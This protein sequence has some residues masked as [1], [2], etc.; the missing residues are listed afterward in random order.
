[1][2]LAVDL[3]FGEGQHQAATIRSNLAGEGK[4]EHGVQRDAS[5]VSV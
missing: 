4:H 2:L 5:L 1:M 3:G